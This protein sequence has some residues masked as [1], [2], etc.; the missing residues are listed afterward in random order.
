MAGVNL[1]GDLLA[2]HN[3]LRSDVPVT[4]AQKAHDIV[5][6]IGHACLQDVTGKDIGKLKL[7]YTCHRPMCLCSINANGDRVGC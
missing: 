6:D 7:K 1:Q 4:N 3:C 2:L 5:G